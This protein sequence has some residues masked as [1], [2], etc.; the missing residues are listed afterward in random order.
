MVNIRGTNI[1]SG[2]EFKPGTKILDLNS[3]NALQNSLSEI[4]YIKIN[5]LS[6]VS[7]H[8]WTD[9]ATRLCL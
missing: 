1:H 3:K 7:S 4:K 9:I 5:E 8:L 6:M 2:F